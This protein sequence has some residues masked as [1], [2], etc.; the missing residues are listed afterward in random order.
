[1]TN[2]PA[3]DSSVMVPWLMRVE[4]RTQK[5]VISNLQVNYIHITTEGKK[6]PKR[7]IAFQWCADFEWQNKCMLSFCRCKFVAIYTHFLWLNPYQN[8]IEKLLDL[9]EMLW[10]TTISSVSSGLLCDRFA[11]YVIG[12]SFMWELS[13]FLLVMSREKAINFCKA[14]HTAVSVAQWIVGL[15]QWKKVFMS[16]NFYLKSRRL[17]VFFVWSE[18]AQG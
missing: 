6:A 13:F 3:V 16:P 5:T 7:E 8:I 14:V 2:E 17:Q 1:M 12:P 10:D 18:N 4:E 11:F 9:Y 15:V